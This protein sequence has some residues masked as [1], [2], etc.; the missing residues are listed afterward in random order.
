MEWGWSGVEWREEKRGERRKKRGKDGKY[1]R[2]E[3]R[4][5]NVRRKEWEERKHSE[6]GLKGKCK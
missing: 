3:G 2:K 1:L 4:N 6:K 5:G